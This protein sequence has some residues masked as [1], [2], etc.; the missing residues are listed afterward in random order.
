MW[1]K[2]RRRKISPVFFVKF[3]LVICTHAAQ[4]GSV[5]QLGFFKKVIL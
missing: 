5:T 2:W 4:W 3:F 1:G